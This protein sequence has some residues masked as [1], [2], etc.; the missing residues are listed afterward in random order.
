[1]VF[2]GYPLHPPGKSDQRRDAHLPAITS[3]MLFFQGTRDPF[4]SPDEMREL[5]KGLPAAT[6]SI[7][8]GGDHSL[9]VAR[10][11]G[12]NSVE[13]AVAEAIA[14]MKHVV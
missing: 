12:A 1:L 5:V 11:A 7:V 6:L 13:T 4:A 10:K 2:F 8:E 3:P 9:A 14:W